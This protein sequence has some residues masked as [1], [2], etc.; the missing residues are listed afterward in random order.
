[1]AMIV[2]FGDVHGDFAV[3]N[4]MLAR[5][6]DEAT[7]LQVGDF[8]LSPVTDA[9]RS[10]IQP[11]PVRRVDFIAG[12]H[13][14]WPWLRDHRHADEPVEIKHNCVFNSQGLIRTIGGRKIGMLGGADSIDKRWRREHVDWFSDERITEADMRRL[15]TTAERLGGVDLLVTHTPPALVVEKML[16]GKEIYREF[17]YSAQCVQLVWDHLGRPPIVCGHMHPE[18]VYVYENVRVLPILG[19]LRL[20]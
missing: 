17:H 12:N 9:H 18:Q 5:V 6:P 1:M 14:Y 10:D 8:G 4:K 2:V 16:A 3:W 13:E 11:Y 20:D 19:V 7:V 15:M